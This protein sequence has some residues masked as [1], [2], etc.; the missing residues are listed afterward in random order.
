MDKTNKNLKPILSWEAPSY[1][2]YERSKRWYIIA[3]ILSF[4]VIAYFI[5]TDAASGA[6][7]VLLLAGVYMISS[8][9]EP[10]KMQV[11]INSLGIK[12]EQKIYTFSSIRFFWI[13][14]N[15]PISST[16]NFAMVGKMGR[17]VTVQLG[18][19]DPAELRKYLLT[20]IAEVEGRSESLF[21]ILSKVLHI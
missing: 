5:L 10:K 4:I 8:N 3:G 19:Q 7:A 15:P 20:Q 17:I 21:D 9:Q 11:S 13:I 18:K 2:K 12:I 16:L 6:I 14:Y 1:I